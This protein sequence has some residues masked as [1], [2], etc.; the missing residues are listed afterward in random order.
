[1]GL[2]QE[3]V[4]H[5]VNIFRDD[6]KA[7]TAFSLT[8][9]SMFVSARPLIHRILCLTTK[10]SQRISTPAEK[11]WYEH[12]YRRK[13]ESH[14]SFMAERDLLK[15][16]R[17][18]IIPN[19]SKLDPYSL[20]QLEHFKSLDRIDTLTID[21]Y[22]GSLWNHDYNHYFAHFY[23][24]LTTLEFHS[25]AGGYLY[26]LQFALQ[27]PNLQNLTFGS[28]LDIPQSGLIPPAPFVGSQSPPLR[29][30]LRCVN[31]NSPRHSLPKEFAFDLPNGINFRSVEFTN[32]DWEQRQ[33]IL[34]GCASSLREYTMLVVGDGESPPQF[35]CAAGTGRADSH[36]QIA[37]SPGSRKTRP[38]S[39]S[40]YVS[41][42]VRCPY[43]R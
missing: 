8:C 1:M 20:G 24:T 41:H 7:L 26:V 4:E 36:S 23:P 35:F 29:G 30:R 19:G 11:K 2:P 31:L 43:W 38:S 15:Y 13:S 18:L 25:P 22:D 40:Y 16:V 6:R 39:P 34:D 28:L 32:V 12:G 5:I 42:L 37:S 3:L 33:Q 21:Y 9:K 17:H 14:L 10:I 27:F